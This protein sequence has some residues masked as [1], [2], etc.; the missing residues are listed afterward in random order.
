MQQTLEARA[1]VRLAWCSSPKSVPSACSKRCRSM[2]PSGAWQFLR[3]A[4]G[5][6]SRPVDHTL[7][8]GL[9]VVLIGSLIAIEYVHTA[10]WR[11]NNAGVRSW[12][13][14]GGGGRGA[15]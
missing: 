12:V 8:L 11:L 14:L 6:H 15:R 3:R 1:A 13:V 9:G 2:L 7:H 5:M 10:I 4:S